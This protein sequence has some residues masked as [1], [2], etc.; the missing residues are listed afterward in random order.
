VPNYCKP[1]Q[2]ST[3]DKPCVDP[4]LK[5]D[6]IKPQCEPDEILTSDNKCVKRRTQE[7]CADGTNPPCTKICKPDEILTSDNQ[8]VKRRSDPSGKC[9][10]GSDPPCKGDSNTTTVLP[11]IVDS[12]FG[13]MIRGLRRQDIPYNDGKGRISFQAPKT[14]P[15]RKT[16]TVDTK[17][18]FVP[19][20]IDLFY[21]KK[22]IQLRRLETKPKPLN[23][24]VVTS[25]RM[26]LQ[27]AISF[28]VIGPG[29]KQGEYYTAQLLPFEAMP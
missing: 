4:G 19:Y 3:P 11:T 23:F 22:R 26:Q 8:C 15:P 13:L 7:K 14:G 21:N 9:A 2:E 17:G 12:K 5:D 28:A 18:V 27:G 10:D 24:T 25:D 16:G 6:Q 29:S 1:G 20:Q